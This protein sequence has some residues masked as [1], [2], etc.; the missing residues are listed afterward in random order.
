[1]SSLDSYYR[2]HWV[3]IEPERFAR[4]DEMFKLDDKRADKLLAPLA[5]APG[6]TAL[7]LGCGP[8]YVAA[9]IALG[10]AVDVKRI[11]DID[12]PRHAAFDRDR[13]GHHGAQS[14]E[15]DRVLLL[16]PRILLRVGSQHRFSLF[17]HAV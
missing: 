11:V 7:D 14:A 16:K 1:M 12:H 9:Q 2:D 10:E 6:Q 8:G 5:L 13:H 17:Q 15:H 3:A 4:Y